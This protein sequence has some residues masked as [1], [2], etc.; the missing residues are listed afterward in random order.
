MRLHA[1]SHRLLAVKIFCGACLVVSGC[2][3]PECAQYSSFVDSIEARDELLTWAD[4]EIF[5]K[6]LL[7][8]DLSGSIL[9]GPGKRKIKSVRGRTLDLPHSLY[10][11]PFSVALSGRSP[12][13]LILGEDV[14]NP[15][16]IFIG[17]VS[18]RGLIISRNDIA[19]TF[20]YLSQNE[21]RYVST[22][23][24]RVGIMCYSD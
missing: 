13:V 17:R 15:V 1:L 21:K 8:G 24:S 5:S 7:E 14:S 12:D 20:R 18:Y 2:T 3:H 9:L 4:T 16:A 23:G 6:K 19:L 10:E 22:Y 11:L